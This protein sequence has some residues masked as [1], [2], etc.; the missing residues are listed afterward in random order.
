[1]MVIVLYGRFIDGES[2]GSLAQGFL[3]LGKTGRYDGLCWWVM[4]LKD[5]R[6]EHML[7]SSGL[8]PAF[9]ICGFSSAVCLTPTER[10]HRTDTAYRHVGSSRWGIAHTQNTHIHTENEKK[11]SLLAGLS[12]EKLGLQGGQLS[13]DS[14]SP[15]LCDSLGSLLNQG[16]AVCLF[17]W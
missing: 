9:A 1:M 7:H 14:A 8:R 15:P 6:S 10:Q 5:W 13:A 12:E 16:L 2:V 17:G 3:W 11:Q 4:E